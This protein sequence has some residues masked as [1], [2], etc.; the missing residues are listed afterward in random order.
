MPPNSVSSFVVLIP[1]RLASTRLPNKP[2][3]DLAGVPMVVRVARQAA[4]SQATRV[5][6]AA[7]DERIVQTVKSFGLEAIKTAGI[8]QSGTDRLAEAV[9]LL[10]LDSQQI[11]VNVQGD[12]PF[13]EP[14]LIDAV[15][16]L[17]HADQD[18][19]M[20]TAGHSIDSVPDFL[21]PNVVKLCMNQLGH[22]VSFSRA[23]IPY[24]RDAF[25][26]SLELRDSELERLA[27]AGRLGIRHIGIY[28]YRCS[29]LQSFAS[30]AACA[31][32]KTEA[33]E[34]L[35]VLDRGLQI[36][37]YLTPNL[38]SP[39]IDTPEDLERARQLLQ[40]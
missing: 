24:P 30:W 20:S 18:C 28:G 23:P 32:E 17:L 25:N 26:Q 3:A 27:A 11:V 9:S 15:A 31:W 29:F 6:V 7:E 21:N 5:V 22:A 2:L 19:V 8:H 38:P 16:E 34:Q 40:N 37:V 10:Q 39:G 13:I 36:G 35:R 12:E 4:R 1:A 33:L 14:S